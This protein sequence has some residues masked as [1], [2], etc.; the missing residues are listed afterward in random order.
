MLKISWVDN[1]VQDSICPVCAT[2]GT[3]KQ[4]LHIWTTPSASAPDRIVWLECS[5]CHARYA[6]PL[7]SADYEQADQHGLKFYLEQGAGIRSMLEPL[8][9]VDARPVRHYVEIGC[10]FGFV[11]DYARLI[12]GWEVFGFDPGFIGA[13]GREGLALPICNRYFEGLGPADPR[14]DLIF[15]SEVIEHLDRPR[16][17]ITRVRDAL[18]ENGVFLLTTP[19]G[20]A[21]GQGLRDEHL[22]PMLSPGQHLILYDDRAITALLREAGFSEIRIADRGHQLH[23]AA[24]AVPFNGNSSHFSAELYLSYLEKAARAHDPRG[25]LGAGLGCRLLKEEVNRG[26]YAEAQQQYVRLREAYLRRYGFDIEM[27][28]ADH[29]YQDQSKDFDEFGESWPLNLAGVLYARAIIQLLHENKPEAAERKFYA[30]SR[31]AVELRRRLQ[32]IGTD[33]A[34][35]AHLCREAEIARLHA[36]T[37]CQPTAAIAA[38]SELAD[39]GLDDRPS[40]HAGRARR[41]VFV[42]LVN[43]GHYGHAERLLSMAPEIETAA[44]SSAERATAFAWGIYLLNHRSDFLSAAAVFRRIWFESLGSKADNAL[45]W[46]ARFHQALATYYQGD[47]ETATLIARELSNGPADV[48]GEYRKRA[49]ELLVKSS[50]AI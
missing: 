33:D 14:V 20:G 30:S 11:M 8:S 15:C 9:L 6:D 29:L 42:D 32:A 23:V 27:I 31:F 3:K 21:L 12:L 37:R 41:Q 36:L 39:S 50:M 40:S 35:S 10:G 13:A 38:L 1:G 7:R 22:A 28:E 18:A 46:S 17:F 48:P 45:L 19:N 2:H 26:R 49:D 5:C 4:V 16:Q 25:P 34:E 47:N 44:A 24:S 43:L